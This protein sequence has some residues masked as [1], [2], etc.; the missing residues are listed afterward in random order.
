MDTLG[1][2]TRIAKPSSLPAVSG[3]TSLRALA[4]PVELG[5]MLR[6][7]ARARRRSLWVVSRITLTT[8]ARQLVVQLALEIMLCLAGSYLS[9]LTPR[10]SVMSS[11]DAGA[12][13]MTFFTVAPRCA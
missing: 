5:I 8:G 6:A 13:M 2:G 3:I 1:V 10:T 11:F 4:A 7:A 12:E 9:W